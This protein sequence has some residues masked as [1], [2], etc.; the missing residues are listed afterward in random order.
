V[1]WKLTD[2]SEVLTA[3]NISALPF[4]F[5]K[6]AVAV[7]F[8]MGDVWADYVGRQV[9][10]LPAGLQIIFTVVLQHMPIDGRKVQV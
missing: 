10:L 5:L 7:L 8:L 2:I 9:A 4:R 6:L 3:S 1:W